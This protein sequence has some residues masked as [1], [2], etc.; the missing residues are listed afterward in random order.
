MLEKELVNTIVKMIPGVQAVYL[1]G[2][3]ASASEQKSSDIDIAFLNEKKLS[4]VDVYRYAQEL[5][6]VFNRD[7]DLL[8]LSSASTVMRMQVVSKGRRLYCYDDYKINTFEMMVYSMYLRFQE[9]RKDILKT[10]KDRGNI[11]G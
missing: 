8:D 11:Y 4:N 7:V 1:F 9:E 10:I 2:S 6:V 3:F 5:A